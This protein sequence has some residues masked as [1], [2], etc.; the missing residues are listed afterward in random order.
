MQPYSALLALDTTWYRISSEKSRAL[1][2][3][4]LKFSSY[5]EDCPF[6]DVFGSA[7]TSVFDSFT[8][9]EIAVMP[10]EELV[11]F[12]LSHG[13]NRLSNPEEIAKTLKSAAN[14]AYRL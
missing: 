3:L 9:D 10:M 5:K 1:N 7:S 12:V 2:L 11:D 13:N 8:P 14:R 6:S 4:Y